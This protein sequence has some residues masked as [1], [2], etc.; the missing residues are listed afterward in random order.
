MV[1]FGDN[2]VLQDLSSYLF[3]VC[4]STRLYLLSHLSG[5]FKMTSHLPLGFLEGLPCFYQGLPF[6]RS[7]IQATPD[8]EAGYL[9]NLKPAWVAE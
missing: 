9:P 3:N 2:P 6:A 4:F 7:I 5:V 1:R 8:S